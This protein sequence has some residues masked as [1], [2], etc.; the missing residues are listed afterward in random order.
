MIVTVKLLVHFR[1]LQSK[2][3]AKINYERAVLQQGNGKLRGNAMRQ[4]EEHN[5]CLLRQ[6]LRIRFA[7][8]QFLRAWM[9]SES[10]HDSR[11]RLSRVLP[12]R[13]RRQ[14]SIRMD[15]EQ[16]DQLLARISGRSNNRDLD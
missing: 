14:L 13:N 5:L 16:T 2:V 15:Q 12:R 1:A 7:E 3:G 10:G 9:M 11:Q 4:R 8:P 6:Q